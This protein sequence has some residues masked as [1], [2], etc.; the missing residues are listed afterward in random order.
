MAIVINETPAGTIDSINAVFTLAETPVTGTVAVYLNGARQAETADYTISGSII[1]FLTAPAAGSVLLA[2]YE[3]TTATPATGSVSE[4]CGLTVS[5]AISSM[6]M[7][8]STVGQRISDDDFMLV[9][10]RANKYFMTG[11]KM[12]TTEREQDF[13][14]FSGVYEY[15]MPSD[16][17]GI[18]PLRRPLGAQSPDFLH[19]TSRGMA[20][21]PYGRKTA[22]KYNRGTPYFMV[23]DT[24]GASLAVHSCDS[25]SDNGTWAVTGD[26]S[27]LVLDEQI[28]VEGSA[29]LRFT[30][31]GSGGTTTLTCTD[32]NQFD[33]TDYLANGWIF[34]NLQCPSTNS[35]SVTSMEIRVGSSATDYYSVTATKR[36]RGDDIGGGWGLIGADI[37]GYSISGTP[38]DDAMDYVQIIITHPTTG[39]NGTYRLDDIFFGQPTYYQLPYYSSQ[40]VLD[41]SGSYKENISAT[42][43]AI[44]CPVEFKEAYIYK[45]LQLVAVERLQDMGLANFFTRELAPIEI[46]LKAKY[47]SME[48]RPSVSY[49]SRIDKL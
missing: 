13:R 41:A 38:D 1:T 14:V 10:N 21:W 31:T 18:I 3:S 15:P 6:Q 8:T 47:P 49:Y 25:L 2:D 40:N 35:A 45:A 48:A 5:D 4:G 28:Y 43:D 34:L 33:I 26:G 16:F 9:L 46:A 17:A 19:G 44:L 20:R 27:G 22:I 29:S 24:E 30:V 11:Y 42:S 23:L 7:E 12:P 39:V 36:H 37:S 32:M